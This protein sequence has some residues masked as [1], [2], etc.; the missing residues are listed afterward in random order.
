MN[1]FLEVKENY[2]NELLIC[3]EKYITSGLNISAT[4]NAIFVHRHTV[5]Y[6]IEKI[7]NILQ[8]RLQ[9]LSG[10]EL[11]LILLSCK[12]LKSKEQ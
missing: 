2:R 6:R 4:A 9:E 8:I 10:N 1:R 5:I 7:E 3:L 11:S 12:R